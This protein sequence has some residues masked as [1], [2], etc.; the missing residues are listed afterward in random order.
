MSLGFTKKLRVQYYSLPTALPLDKGAMD[1]SINAVDYSFISQ[2]LSYRD[3]KVQ[4]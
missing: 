3:N 1:H 2:P 4:T